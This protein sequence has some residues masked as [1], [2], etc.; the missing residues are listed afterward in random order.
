MGSGDWNDGLNRVG[1]QGRGESTWLGFFIHRLLLDFAP[2][3]HTRGHADV[4]QR[5][6]QRAQLLAGNLEL[7]WDGEWYRRGYFDDG[8]AL[9]S[10]HSEECQIDSIAQSWSVL[11]GAVPL[12]YAEQAM[13]AVRGLLIVRGAG[14]VRLL[15]PP[16][17]HAEPNP[18]YIRGYPPGVRENGAQYT[19]AALW[20]VM[21]L[22]GLGCGDEATEVLHMLNPVNHTRT[23][24]DVERYKVEPYVVAGDVHSRGALTGRGGWSWYTGSAGWMY[25]VG[26]ESILGL[27]K[28]GE[29]FRLEPCIPSTW[30]SYSLTWQLGRNHYQITVVNPD[31]RCRGVASVELDGR[32]VDD[33]AI[34]LIDDGDVHTV[35]VVMG[36]PVAQRRGAVA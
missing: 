23:A 33:P 3:C 15:T 17:D 26:L 32:P 12:A 34:P 19:H 6:E 14:L 31:H 8:S 16:F 18:G 36:D 13:D 21:A 11:S 29:T 1:P 30:P 5:Y 2:L 27:R 7:A 9:G 24:G 35:R 10:A 28:T 25:R 20:V 4:A 22:A